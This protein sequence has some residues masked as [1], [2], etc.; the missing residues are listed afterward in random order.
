MCVSVANEYLEYEDD[1]IEDPLDAN[2]LNAA[3]SDDIGMGVARRQATEEK[4]KR[5]KSSSGMSIG[6]YL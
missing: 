6:Q 3:M 2:A 5:Y 4:R 1:V